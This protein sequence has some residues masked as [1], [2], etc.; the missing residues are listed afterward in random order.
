VI[1]PWRSYR[2][3]TYTVSIESRES[4]PF[5]VIKVMRGLGYLEGHG[6]IPKV[7]LSTQ[8]R[9]MR[10]IVDEGIGETSPLWQ[11]FQAWLGERQADIV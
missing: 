6:S 4:R 11:Q 1:R 5:S 10:V 2:V 3:R 8:R 7:L 9:S